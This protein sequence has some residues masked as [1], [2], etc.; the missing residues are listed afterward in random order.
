MKIFQGCSDYDSALDKRAKLLCA[1]HKGEESSSYCPVCNQYFTSERYLHSHNAQKHGQAAQESRAQP[2]STQTNL[3]T[4]FSCSVM[5]CNFTSSS[6]KGIKIH[7][8]RKHSS[9]TVNT[10]GF[11]HVC[12]VPGCIFTSESTK[13][14]KI[15]LRKLQCTQMVQ[16]VSGR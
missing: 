10:I 8:S 15:H 13:G 12:L 16:R 3:S 2:H 9:I 11:V 4:P 1:C 7:T 5:G 6:T 14:V